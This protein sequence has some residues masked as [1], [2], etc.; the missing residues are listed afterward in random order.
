MVVEKEIRE[1]TPVESESEKSVESE[2]SEY[3]FS[4]IDV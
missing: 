2:E 1:P 3:D 4:A